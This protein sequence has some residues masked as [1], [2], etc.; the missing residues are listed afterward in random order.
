M[1]QSSSLSISLFSL[2]TFNNK[3]PVLGRRKHVSHRNKFCNLMLT[4]RSCFSKTF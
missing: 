1:I 4:I 2:C 3:R